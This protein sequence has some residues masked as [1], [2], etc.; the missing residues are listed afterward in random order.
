MANLTARGADALLGLVLDA[1]SDVYSV[2]HPG[3]DR[4]LVA[5]PAA[6]PVAAAGAAGAITGSPHYRVAYRRKGG[7]RTTLGPA[8]TVALAAQAAALSG[9]PVSGD[10]RVDARELFRSD[11][12]E[13]SAP[14][15]V[16]AGGGA[17]LCTNGAHKVA[18][19]FL[20]N[21]VE[22]DRSDSVTVTIVDNSSDG[23]IAASDLDVGPTGTT[24]RLIYM[25]KAG[26]A[27]FYLAHTIA[28]NSTT[29]YTLSISDSSLTSL[30]QSGERLDGTLYAR[31]YFWCGAIWDN[32][33]TTFSDDTAVG[34]VLINTKLT[35]PLYNETDGNWNL[36]FLKPDS[37][38]LSVA[39]GNI[40]PKELTGAAGIGRSAPGAIVVGGTLKGA[41]RAGLVVPWASAAIGDGIV[42]AYGASDP[43]R[44]TYFTPSYG[45]LHPR[46]LTF[47][48][49]LG[50]DVPPELYFALFVA[51]FDWSIKAGQLA[52][53]SVTLVGLHHTVAGLGEVSV[54]CSGYKGLFVPYGMR[55]DAKALTDGVYVKVASS[56]SAGAFSI[57]EKVG[58]GGSY[59]TAQAV[60][61]NTTS[62]KQT[63]GPNY[64]SDRVELYDDAGNVLGFWDSENRYPFAMI[65]TGDVTGLSATD[66][67]VLPPY[68]RVVGTVAPS[69]FTVTGVPPRRI[70]TP[71]FGGAHCTV[72]RDSSAFEAMSA[73]VKVTTPRAKI[74]GLG[75]ESRVP[76]DIE[77]TD[78]F[79]CEI[80]FTRRLSSNEWRNRMAKNERFQIDVDLVGD[81]IVTGLGTVSAYRER[82]LLTC[83]QMRVDSVKHTVSGPNWIMET[84]TA[85]AEQPDDSSKELFTLTDWT[86]QDWEYPA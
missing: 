14:T 11:S 84:V 54:G 47:Y 83:P 7:A 61:Y 4:V 72:K 81:P 20:V 86:R 40:V 69:E 51:G 27:V 3:L 10:A 38:D 26:G 30:D 6:A 29:S 23:K 19:S 64:L 56:P 16:L 33:T 50:G 12:P 79:G 31:S 85:K 25:T 76:F 22:S 39:Y 77:H 5:P 55:S 21:G 42:T 32:V 71:R 9:V 52:E 49:Y 63:R 65:A 15:A 80:T 67:M 46:S 59:N 17:G 45:K 75:A 82:S 8:A 18:V 57:Q 73:D 70:A 43:T 35:P 37:W 1:P 60:A 44:K 34:S 58:S 48:E 74:E 13:P 36:A 68:L 28:D 53:D 2:G 62:K 78:Y 41:F 66:V 24:A